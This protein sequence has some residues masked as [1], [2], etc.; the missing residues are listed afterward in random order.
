M[1]TAKRGLVAVGLALLLAWPAGEL[2]APST[3]A[4]S[5]HAGTSKASKIKVRT[6]HRGPGQAR[7]GAR[8]GGAA[9]TNQLLYNGGRVANVPQV[10]LTFWGPEW[11]SEQPAK[12]YLQSFFGVVGGSDWLAS[13]TQYCSGQLNSPFT[14]CLGRF[15]Q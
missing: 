4:A 6:A 14:S 5:T 3:A 10:Y 2:L 13:T 11:T 15:V 9:A 7:A 12:D 8:T 1:R